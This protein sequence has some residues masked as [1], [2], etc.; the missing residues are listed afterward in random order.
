MAVG[1]DAHGPAAASRKL[2]REDALDTRGRSWLRSHRRRTRRSHAPGRAR[3]R[4]ARATCSR[5]AKIACV[6]SQR[7]SPSGRQ[8]ATAACVSSALWRWAGVSTVSSTR[9]SASASARSE[10][11]RATLDRVLGEP[12]LV[13]RSVDVGVHRQLL[14]HGRERVQ[15]CDRRLGRVGCNGRDQ[16]DRRTRPLRSEANRPATKPGS[17]RGSPGSRPARSRCGRRPRR[18]RPGRR[19]RQPARGRAESGAP[20]REASRGGRRRRCTGPHPTRVRARRSAEPVDRRSRAPRRREAAQARPPTRRA[21][22]AP[23]YRPSISLPRADEPERHRLPA[24]RRIARSIF[25]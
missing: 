14:V 24:A 3:A 19:G 23:L 25:G 8:S 13:E 7:V 22:T 1:D 15:A 2:C 17:D 5:A 6:D 21:P 20:H 11:P 4:S 18:G 16:P 9:T 12:E 10:S